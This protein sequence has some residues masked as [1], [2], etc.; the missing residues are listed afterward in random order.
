MH[1]ADEAAVEILVEDERLGEG[2]QVHESGQHVS[3][4]H[5][6]LFVTRKGNKLPARQLL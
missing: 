6:L 3:S 2:D 5:V 4:P 1:A